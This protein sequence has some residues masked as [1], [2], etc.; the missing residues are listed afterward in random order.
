MVKTLSNYLISELNFFSEKLQCLKT[1][2]AVNLNTQDEIDFLDFS[3]EMTE[4]NIKKIQE[5]LN[6]KKINKKIRFI[7]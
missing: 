7:N 4:N 3:K 6:E 2:K 5:K 1:K